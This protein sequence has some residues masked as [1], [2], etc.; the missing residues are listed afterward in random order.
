MFVRVLNTLLVAAFFPQHKQNGW[1]STVSRLQSHYEK[2]V[3]FLSVS[4]RRSWYSSDQPRKNEY[5][6]YS[7]AHTESFHAN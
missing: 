5:R 3:Y 1:G 6:I 4:L 7:F 2:T